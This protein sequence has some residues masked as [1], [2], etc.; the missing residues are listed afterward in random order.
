MYMDVYIKCVLVNIST[1]WMCIY[2][3]NIK[4]VLKT[5]EYKKCTGE[6]IKIVDVYIKCV[7]VNISTSWMR[8]YG[9]DIKCVLVTILTKWMCI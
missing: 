6:Y 2:G 5:I 8:I 3:C 1:S 7:L 9:C 4:C